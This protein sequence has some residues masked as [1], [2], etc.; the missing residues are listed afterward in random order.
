MIPLLQNNKSNYP[1]IQISIELHSIQ[2]HCYYIFWVSFPLLAIFSA[3][4]VFCYDE[5][6]IYLA[7]FFA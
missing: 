4:D 5:A 2:K 7:R 3:Y 6:K 1:F